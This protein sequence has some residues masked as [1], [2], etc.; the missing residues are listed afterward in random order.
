M[1]T[2]YTR[3]LLALSN[4]VAQV[5]VRVPPARV[6]IVTDATFVY[7]GATA[8]DLVLV[9]ILEPLLAFSGSRWTGPADKSVSS[10]SGRVAIAANEL[11]SIW[12][13]S[14]DPWDVTLC[15]WDFEA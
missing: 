6:W 3:R 8:N 11:L 7:R 5:N 9:A 13:L 4:S 2:V 12:P 15:G 14:H 1:G 10:W